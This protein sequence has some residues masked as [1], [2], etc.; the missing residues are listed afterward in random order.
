MTA[1]LLDLR[2][3]T[4]QSFAKGAEVA[5]AMLPALTTNA[6]RA[7]AARALREALSVAET[8]GD[9]ETIWQTKGALSV[10]LK[11]QEG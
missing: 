4:H 1:A 10:V 11:A 7:E 8:A 9:T 3:P 2:P 6:L 5:T